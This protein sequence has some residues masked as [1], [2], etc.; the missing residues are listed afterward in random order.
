MSTIRLTN[1]VDVSLFPNWRGHDEVR[2]VTIEDGPLCV[3]ASDRA[4]EDDK[5]LHCELI[6]LR[7]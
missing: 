4:S 5:T 7:I 3:L 6:W 2:L 1:H